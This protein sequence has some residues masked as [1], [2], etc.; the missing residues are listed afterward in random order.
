M[1]RCR[2][3]PVS[4]PNKPIELDIAII[5]GGSAGMTLAR[6]LS[7]LTA[8]VFEPK[9]A[10][11]R[12]FSWA[13][14]AQPQQL[15]ELS[16]AIKGSWDSWRF[17]D[18]SGEVIHQS[19]QYRYASLSSS[20]YL[21]H[22]EAN[23]GDSVNLV[24][25]S[26]D[27]LESDDSGGGQFNSEGQIY[28]AKTIYDS[29]PPERPDNCLLQHF[30]GWEISTK[31][32]ISE[33]NIATLMDF[34]VDQSRGL[35]FIYVLPYSDRHLLVES[36]MISTQLEDKDWYR[37]AINQWLDDRKIQVKSQL[38]EE[39]GVIPMSAVPSPQDGVARIGAASGAVRL[40]SG[41]A[42]STIQAQMATLAN[43]IAAGDRQVPRPF[44]KSLIFMD[45]VFN[46]VLSTQP[47]HRVG[48]FMAIA[49]T[50]NADAFTRFM[51]GCAGFSDWAQVI[52][53]MPKWPFI[54]AA[55]AEAFSH[56]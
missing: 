29:R 36:T 31:E 10:A 6:K 8:A 45:K 43:S 25:Q 5:G 52:M 48:L 3:S 49:K 18:H 23:L 27:R 22:C 11:E 37:S 46:R 16:P 20:Q 55:V 40:S 12:D 2:D 30:I 47:K 32:P 13:L 34:R 44:S 4:I 28:S 7:A 41:Y 39:Y 17:V 21:Q 42:F 53:A 19:H 9:L 14:W 50:L 15:E 51:L 24:R 56:D 1:K 54:K 38:R 35:H 26:I 33:A